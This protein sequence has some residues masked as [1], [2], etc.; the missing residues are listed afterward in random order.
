MKGV[1]IQTT[2]SK[3]IDGTVLICIKNGVVE[4]VISDLQLDVQIY[5]IENEGYVGKPSRP[6]WEYV[7]KLTGKAMKQEIS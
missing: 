6:L 3:K 1:D 7:R 5:D 2:P 4:E